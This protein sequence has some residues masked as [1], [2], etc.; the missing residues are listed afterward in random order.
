MVLLDHKV[1]LVHRAPMVLLDYQVYKDQQDLRV[2][3]DQQDL[4]GL[5]DQL[6]LTEYKVLL[7]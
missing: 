5:K 7:D 2:L 6:G 3:L 1:S 4:R